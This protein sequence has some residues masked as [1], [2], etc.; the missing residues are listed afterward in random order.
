MSTSTTPPATAPAVPSPVRQ[1]WLDRWHEEIIEPELPIVDPHHH[2]WD[3]PGWRYLLDELLA[4][5]QSGHNLIATVFVQCRAM[6]RR[7][8]PEELTPVGET[9]FVNGVAAMSAS[10]GYGPARI[11]AGIVGHADLRLGHRVEAVLEAHVHARGG[12][13]PGIRPL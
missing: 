4:D 11:C 8:G 13:V 1:E 10:G 12:P 6:Y 5:V 2:L 3:R 7:D 9:E